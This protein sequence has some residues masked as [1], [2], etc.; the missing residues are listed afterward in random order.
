MKPDATKYLNDPARLEAMLKKTGWSHKDAA[1]QIGMD[2]GLF[3]RK[4]AGK[5]SHRYDFQYIIE[6]LCRYAPPRSKT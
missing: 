6:S 2:L 4:L 5:V 3:G 1:S